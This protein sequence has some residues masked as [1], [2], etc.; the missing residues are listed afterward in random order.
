MSK[1]AI[2]G[3]ESGTATFTIEAPATNTDRIFELPDEAGK[4]LTD[5]GV[6]TSAMPAGSVIQVVSVLHETETSTTSTSFV[7]TGLSATIMPSSAN[8]KILILVSQSL[9]LL[10]SNANAGIGYRLA[11]TVNSSTTSLRPSHM[12]LRSAIDIDLNAI[13]LP[14]CL[15]QLDSPNTTS[16]VT[17]FTQMSGATNI[18]AFTNRGVNRTSEITLMEIAG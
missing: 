1:I 17:Y 6:P 4:I 15:N 12:L 18:T 2:K 13:D 16:P 11:K 3:N 7:S 5:V 9:S 14:V 10:S 8:S